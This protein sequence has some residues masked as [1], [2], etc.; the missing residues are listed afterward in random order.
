MSPDI[1]RFAWQ[2]KG[3]LDFN[4]MHFELKKKSAG[5]LLEFSIFIAYTNYLGSLFLLYIL[6]LSASDWIY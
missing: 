6:Y 4:Y 1:N 5:E 2:S 3:G